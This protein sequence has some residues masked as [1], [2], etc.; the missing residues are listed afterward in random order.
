MAADTLLPLV[1]EFG[2]NGTKVSAHGLCRPT[3]HRWLRLV[4]WGV[5]KPP[6]CLEG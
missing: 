1:A 6:G 3:A 5:D 2:T 4:V